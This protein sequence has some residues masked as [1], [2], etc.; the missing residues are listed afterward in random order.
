MAE[1]SINYDM[2]VEKANSINSL[3][4]DLLI[5]LSRLGHLRHN[6]QQNWQGE[7]AEKYDLQCESLIK[8]LMK[9]HIKI[10]GF[11]DKIIEIADTIKAADEAVSSEGEE[12]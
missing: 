11:G 7:A 3:T 2:V 1:T 9:V 8:Y 5:V 6:I 4:G 12:I 10:G